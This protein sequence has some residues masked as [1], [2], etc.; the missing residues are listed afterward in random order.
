MRTQEADLGV[1]EGV[2]EIEVDSQALS[3]ITRS[4]ID[5]QI[6]TAHK[7]PRSIKR[8]RDEALQMVT[9]D[10]AIATECIY[11]LP[12]KQFDRDTGQ[13]QT[14]NIEGP[15]ARFAEVIGS[16]WGNARVGAR[17]VNDS[18]GFITAQGLFHDLERN[19]AV[20][21]EVQRGITTNRGDRF[22]PDM[23]A[24][25][26]NAA[27]SIALRNAIL[28]GVPKAFWSGLYQASRQ[29]AM[30]DFK[31]LSNRRSDAL[32]EFQK[33][34]VSP[35]M[36]Y[37]K[38]MVAGIEDIGLEH[39]LA[40]RGL[41]TALR[42]GDTTPEQ[43]FAPDEQEGAAKGSDVKMPKSKAAM[44]GTTG[45]EKKGGEP[46]NTQGAHVNQAAA[47]TAAAAQV[48]GAGAAIDAAAPERGGMDAAFS[49]DV[50]ARHEPR[51]DSGLQADGRVAVNKALTTPS[52][53]DMPSDS[54]F[55]DGPPPEDA[56]GNL[57]QS[58]PLPAKA[59]PGEFMATAGEISSMM[60]RA[61]AKGFKLD[62]LVSLLPEPD[63]VGWDADKT[64]IVSMTKED[65]KLLKAQVS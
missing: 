57:F 54:P 52:L 21:F 37:A 34:G 41:I 61:K 7:W 62:E 32:K 20:G 27:S 47:A 35:E 51:Q 55:D 43:A 25:T 2:R 63:K 29:C 19:W 11:C 15:S 59:K 53:S 30:G 12:R 5:M 45:M 14:V 9:L 31:T 10:E 28:K 44:A 64:T 60:A 6:A 1:G 33:F 49:N 17:I 26:G 16:A 8:F 48:T 23:I 39:L 50:T 40:M 38:F 4:E 36:I 24:V 22:K 58:L 46:I 3:L 42:D 65:C 56:S 18:N 13:W